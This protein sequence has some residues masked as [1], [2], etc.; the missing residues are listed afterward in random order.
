MHLFIALSGNGSDSVNTLN[1]GFSTSGQVVQNND[2]D[3]RNR[4]SDTANT[5][6]IDTSLDFQYAEFLIQSGMY[7]TVSINR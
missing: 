4:I 7:D 3:I 1:A 6:D 5:V 2:A